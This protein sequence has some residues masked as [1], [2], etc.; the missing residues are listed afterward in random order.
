M[1]RIFMVMFLLLLFI[2][3]VG[4]TDQPKENPLNNNSTIASIPK[5][6]SK[7]QSG[8]DDCIYLV[9]ESSENLISVQIP[10]V[11]T[12]NAQAV[13]ACV[14]N[15][16]Y[17]ELRRWLLLEKCDLKES[18]IPIESI[19]EKMN[20]S[21]YSAYYLYIS[22]HV[23]F[24]SENMISIIFTGNHNN[25]AAAHPNEV[26][27]SINVAVQTAERIGVADVYSIDDT[28]YDVF[29]RYVNTERIAHDELLSLNIFE[30]DML[31][32]G[33]ALEPEKEIYSYFTSTCIGISY[34]VAY[35]LGNHVEAE[36]P[37]KEWEASKR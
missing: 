8:T 11:K 4:C 16:V 24:E 28:L 21:K 15:Q 2:N 26:F 7:T 20:S 5:T 31:L 30:K 34:P 37:Y 22:S 13:N 19:S 18:V 33:I 27:F 29:L 23:S 35:A 17:R 12:V 10:M 3:L 1:K 32:E 25:K 6:T 14:K 36:I 9:E